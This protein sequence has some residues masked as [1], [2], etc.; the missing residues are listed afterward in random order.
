MKKFST[1]VP[2]QRV[3]T[4]NKITCPWKQYNFSPKLVLPTET[5]GCNERIRN[6]PRMSI[7]ITVVKLCVSHFYVHI[8]R[9]FAFWCPFIDYDPRIVYKRLNFI[10]KYSQCTMKYTNFRDMYVWF[11]RFHISISIVFYSYFYKV[12]SLL[13]IE[14]EK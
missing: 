4:E 3:K 7:P 14:N 11:A 1:F 9:L 13:I 5:A 2:G 10:S 6:F 12:T 8:F